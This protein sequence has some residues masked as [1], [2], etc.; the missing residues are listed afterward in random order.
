MPFA[1]PKPARDF[2]PYASRMPR[3]PVAANSSRLC[4]KGRY[5]FDYVQHR[6]RLT[7]PLVRKPGVPKHKDFVVDPERWHEVFREATWEDALD[8]AAQGLR[9]TRDTYGSA[10]SRASVRRKAPTR[11]RISFRSSY[12]PALGRTTSITARASAM[13]RASPR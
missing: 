12:A 6:H 10:R 5:G 8:V 11:R 9:Q 1:E 7:K 2:L 3:N 13:R 4:V